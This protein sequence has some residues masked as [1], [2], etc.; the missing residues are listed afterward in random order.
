M[1]GNDG[2]T[3]AHSEGLHHHAA[4]RSGAHAGAVLITQSN[5][6]SRKAVEQSKDFIS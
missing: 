1:V 3:G 5:P 4:E 6:G 2:G